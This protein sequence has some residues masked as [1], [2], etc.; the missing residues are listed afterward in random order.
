MHPARVK[1]QKHTVN[2]RT[3][4]YLRALLKEARLDATALRALQLERLRQILWYAFENFSFY[5]EHFDAAGFDPYQFTNMEQIE[6]VPVLSKAD[7][8]AFTNSLLD[9]YPVYYNSLYHDATSGSTGKPLPI[10]RTWDERALM[11]AKW[12]RVMHL[13]GHKF[14][15]RTFSVTNPHRMQKDSILQNLGIMK[16][17]LVSQVAPVECQIDEYLK[18]KPDVL[19]GNKALLLQMAIHAHAHAIELPAPRFYI[20]AGE[21]L[22]GAGRDMLGSVFGANLAEVYGAVE[23]NTLG[24]R[25]QGE[26]YFQISHSTNLVEIQGGENDPHNGSCLITDFSVHSIPL[27]RYELDD[28]MKTHT[29]N[30]IPVIDEIAGR[31]NDWILLRDGSRRTFAPF[32]NVIRRYPQ[33]LQFR[34]VQES[35][36]LLRLLLVRN[37]QRPVEDIELKLLGE[38]IKE[39]AAE[40]VHFQ[41][42]WCDKLPPDPNGKLR[43]LISKVE[44]R[45]S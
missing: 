22:D 7:Y 21:T 24:W 13:C 18:V 45:E 12:M 6:Q 14:S 33:I 20:C 42:E 34:V 2:A 4:Y 1:W 25:L 26:N 43:V 29:V 31:N 17:Y 36:S 41:I 11:V 9:Q 16:R 19:Y 27:I 5:R 37:P 32:W 10:R 38:L 35:L 30:H 28:F 15:D 3:L 23:F 44:S 8:R 39:T 40:G